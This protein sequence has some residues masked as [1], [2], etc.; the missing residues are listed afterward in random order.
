MNNQGEAPLNVVDA[1]AGI[2]PGSALHAIRRARPEFVD[3]VEACRATVLWPKNDQG[4]P[5]ALRIALAQRIARLSGN[6]AQ[7][8][9]YHTLAQGD[10][11]QAIANGG[12]PSAEDTWLAAI[13]RHSD[14]VTLQPRH[15]TEQHIHTLAEAGLNAPQIVALTELIA[16]VNFE[17]RVMAGLQLLGAL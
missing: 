11:Y 17:S 13:V 6:P 5:S 1:V 15:S 3:G 14:H 8:A 10:A 9:F 4:L 12:S 16:F 7:A 2:A